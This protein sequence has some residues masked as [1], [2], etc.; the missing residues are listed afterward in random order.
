MF[1]PLLAF[2]GVLILVSGWSG[3]LQV[4]LK[5]RAF[6]KSKEWYIRLFRW[7]R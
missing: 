1:V 5:G 2:A 6:S 3:L 7:H 4:Y